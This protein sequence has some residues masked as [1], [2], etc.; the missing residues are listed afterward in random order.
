MLTA[1]E[2]YPL[3]L[4]FLQAGRLVAHATARRS[5]ADHLAA[6]LCA[7]SLRASPRA[8]SLLS[9]GSVPARQRLRRVAR[10]LVRPSLAPA[11]LSPRLVRAAIRLLRHA[12]V[13][14]EPGRPWLVALDSVRCHSWE[15]F[16]LGVVAWGRTLPIGWAVLPYPWPKGR[17]TPTV[18]A[19]LEQVGVSWP[20]GEPVALLADRAFPSKAL[21]TTLRR[22]GWQWTVRL[23]GRHAVEFLDERRCRVREL[24]AGRR[25]PGGW[26]TYAVTFGAGSKLRGTLMIGPGLPV[27]PVHQAGQA[28]LA[29]RARQAGRRAQHAA[30]KHPGRSTVSYDAWVVLFS[31]ETDPLVADAQYRSRWGIEGTY[32]DAQGGW[33]GTQGWALEPTLARVKKAAQVEA[34]AGQWAL[35][36]LVQTW[37]GL[38]LES[39][40]VG[41]QARKRWATTARLSVWA[42]G[43]FALADP[44][45]ALQA[46]VRATLEEGARVLEDAP[47][48]IIWYQR[49]ATASAPEQEAA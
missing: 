44:D 20:L 34:L 22:Y 28:S 29:A 41:Q 4:A 38:R 36:V 30:T 26:D 48:P 15:L 24:V 9:A 32:R 43:K 45:P 11:T 6:L 19:L 25:P 23:Q 14:P 40:A 18:C 5:V 37:L 49:P 17:F 3:L 7:Q 8:R 10:A 12:G 16:T 2:L 33:D 46:W 42:R 21:F 27:I 13:G 35:G 39:S 1:H 31:T 47:D